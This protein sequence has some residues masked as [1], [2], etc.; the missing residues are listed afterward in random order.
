MTG[1]EFGELRSEEA[2]AK[3]KDL[4]SDDEAEAAIAE[5]HADTEAEVKKAD[6]KLAAAKEKLEQMKKDGK[7][8]VGDYELK[9]ET[10]DKLT[11]QAKSLSSSLIK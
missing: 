7:I 11:E 9:K 1:K 3:V 2:K 4:K 8:S 6:G 10:L 5:T